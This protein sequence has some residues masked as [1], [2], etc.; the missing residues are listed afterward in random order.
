MNPEMREQLCT[1]VADGLA[2]EEERA[3]L[4]RLGEDV[5]LWES[6]PSLV[7]SALAPDEL[8]ELADGVL[9]RLGL[10]PPDPDA[11][12]LGE[13]VREAL[14]PGVLPELSAAVLARVSAADDWAT[15]SAALREA[16]V[17]SAGTV[18]LADAVMARVAPAEAALSAFADGALP[19]SEQAA[20]AARLAAD[21]AARAELASLSE[22]SSLVGEA[23][24]AGRG[25]APDL[26][27]G[28]AAAIGVDP[29]AVPG[30]D[31]TLLNEAVRAEA[32]AV[33]IAGAV[34]DRLA[35]ARPAVVPAEPRE[36]WWSRIWAGLAF[37][38]VAAAAAAL[39]FAMPGPERVDTS[40]AFTFNVTRLV[41]GS[42]HGVARRVRLP[43]G[44]D[45]RVIR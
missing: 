12:R 37:P 43:L 44:G 45:P 1:R 31:P 27:T 39:L 21:P 22:L 18:D 28:V 26:W 32:G 41:A 2:S 36:S 38:A 19:A 9:A 42:P 30:W 23:L 11:P 17:S 14:S 8:P 7:Q 25:T 10:V 6:L 3:E 24:R 4:E 16:V 29:D 34:M 15:A 40:G 35:P 5:S 20:V 33:D 13:V